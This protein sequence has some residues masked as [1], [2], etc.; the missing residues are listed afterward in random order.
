MKVGEPIREAHG[1]VVPG[2]GRRTLEEVSTS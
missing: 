2:D 1:L